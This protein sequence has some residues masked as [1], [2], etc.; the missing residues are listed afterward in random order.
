MTDA[1][2]GL[3]ER[4][5]ALTPDWGTHRIFSP[6][7][8]RRIRNL[9]V[10]PIVHTEVMQVARIL[11]TCWAMTEDGPVLVALRALTEDAASI[12]RAAR[13]LTAL[14]LALQAYPVVVAADATIEGRI[15]VDRVVA[16]EP[17]D[18]GAPLMLGDGRVSRATVLRARA[19]LAAM[20]GL[21]ATRDLTRR[22][23]DADLLEPWP[24]DF[25]IGAG[26]RV[27]H[28][29]FRVLARNRL[30]DPALYAAIAAHG[31]EAGLLVAAHRLSLF[32][33]SSL[34]A[35]ARAAVAARPSAA[36]PSLKVA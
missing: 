9:A 21:D 14:P 33:M 36:D 10:V 3:Y 13:A 24:L 8:Y 15:L 5:T 32:R 4:P 19:A 16:D 35:A 26:E 34:V 2:A 7:A 11:P 30:D 28:D 31:V 17:T 1:W 12:P 18:V 23:A 25:D 29:R 27:R 20:R 22:L 6:L